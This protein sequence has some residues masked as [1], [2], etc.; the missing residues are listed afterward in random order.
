MAPASFAAPIDG[1]TVPHPE[2]AGTARCQCCKVR[3]YQWAHPQGSAGAWHL[4]D[5]AGAPHCR[6]Q[7]CKYHSAS[8]R[9]SAQPGSLC[10][11]AYADHRE[12]FAAHPPKQ[13][14]GKGARV[15][16][17]VSPAYVEPEPLPEPLQVGGQVKPVRQRAQRA[18]NPAGSWP[19]AQGMTPL[20]PSPAPVVAQP[21]PVVDQDWD[22]QPAEDEPSPLAGL[23][24]DAG[25]LPCAAYVAQDDEEQVAELAIRQGRNV[26]IAGPPGCGKTMLVEAIA[27]KLGR[28]VV[29][30]LGADGLPYDHLIGR[31]DISTGPDGSAVTTWRDGLIPAAMRAGDILYLDEVTAL[32]VGIRSAA[33]A[34]MDWRRQITLA[35]NGNELVTAAPGFVCVASFNP[36]SI[37]G[38]TAMAGPLHGRFGAIIR[39]AY[40][41]KAAEAA[42]LV[43]RVPGLSKATAALMAETAG[44]IREAKDVGRKLNRSADIGTR[45]LLDWAALHVGGL[46]LRQAARATLGGMS[47]DPVEAKVIADVIDAT[48]PAEGG[49]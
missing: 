49:R 4:Y 42:L 45:N 47:F 41:S 21:A 44:K 10:A 39:L 23:V 46:G 30:V 3:A 16:Q 9:A 48:L 29:T 34:A 31:R 35:E 28:K 14:A 7:G 8:A 43:A 33:Y 13:R 15:A 2:K 36:G 6:W 20:A 12:Y 18:P 27:R 1:A 26:V 24:D 40:L 11:Q 19:G 25:V 37:A 38:T 32:P 5:A 17:P 22:L